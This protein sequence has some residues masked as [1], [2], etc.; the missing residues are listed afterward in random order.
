MKLCNKPTYPLSRMR[1]WQ[2]RKPLSMLRRCSRRRQTRASLQSPIPAS[3]RNRLRCRC[4]LLAPGHGRRRLRGRHRTRRGQTAR[5]RG[6]P[7]EPRQKTPPGRPQV[8]MQGSR[9]RSKPRPQPAPSQAWRPASQASPC[10]AS[11]RRRSSVCGQEQTSARWWRGR[12]P[13][14]WVLRRSPRPPRR[15]LLQRWG[16]RP[17]PEPARVPLRRR[18]V[19]RSRARVR[20]RRRGSQSAPVGPQRPTRRWPLPN[21]WHQQLRPRTWTKRSSPK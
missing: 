9:R 3:R 21:L 7:R 15:R 1:I 18:P 2:K 8:R 13:S 12:W 14:Q 17:S 11:V 19:G 20:A 6:R 4:L 10:L 5:A 16:F